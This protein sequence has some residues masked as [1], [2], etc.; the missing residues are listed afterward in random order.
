VSARAADVEPC[1]HPEGLHF[2]C[3]TTIMRA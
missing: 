2:R 1:D 3:A